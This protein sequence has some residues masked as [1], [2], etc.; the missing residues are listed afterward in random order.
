[1]TNKLKRKTETKP[2]PAIVVFGLDE[3]NKPK[4]AWFAEQQASWPPR[5]PI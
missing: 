5:P 4:A 1:M 2:V 3:H